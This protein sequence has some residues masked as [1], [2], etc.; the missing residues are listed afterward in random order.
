MTERL[1][2]RTDTPT[3]RTI[4][5]NSRETRFRQRAEHRSNLQRN[6]GRQR[7]GHERGGDQGI[8]IDIN[9]ETESVAIIKNEL[10]E[11][12]G[13]K[14]RIGIRIGAET[15]DIRCEDNQ[16]EGFAVP[17]SDLRKR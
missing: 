3:W 2:P 5:L 4:C 12:R 17:I 7:I 13:T 14:S 8:A 10:K 1:P 11:T 9:G 16:I 6:P 15:R